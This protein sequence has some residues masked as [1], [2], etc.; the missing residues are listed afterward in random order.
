MTPRFKHKRKTSA[1]PIEFRRPLNFIKESLSD[2]LLEPKLRQKIQQEEHDDTD[3][4]QV[5]GHCYVATEA[6]YWLFGRKLGYKPQ[7]K[8]C[9]D[10]GT[11]WWLKHP[12]TGIVVDPTV[13]Q[14]DGDFN[15][16]SGKGGSFRIK[17]PSKRCKILIGRVM[18]LN[19][20][21]SQRNIGSLK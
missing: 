7:V 19:V 6:A 3:L 20:L 8:R 16:T 2:D 5:R 9:T 18:E 4:R 14:T 17:V 11:H 15:Y 10:G 12:E 21:E 13:D 1:W